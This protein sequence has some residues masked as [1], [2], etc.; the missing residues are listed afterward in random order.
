MK[1]IASRKMKK[2]IYIREIRALKK[3]RNLYQHKLEEL[4]ALYNG[5]QDQR[6]VSMAY[7]AENGM[8]EI[9]ELI[10]TGFLKA[11]AF[12]V[13][14][15]FDE[16]RAVYYYGA[17]PFTEKGITFLY[18]KRKAKNLFRILLIAGGCLIAALLIASFL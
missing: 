10:D 4:Y 6:S 15:S 7:T 2:D 17:Y 18:E 13:K 1:C 8:L 5:W 14:K 3:H 12:D 9:L 16:Y 11:D